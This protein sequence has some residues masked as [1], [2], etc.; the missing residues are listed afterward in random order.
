[1][2]LGYLYQLTPPIA[3]KTKND[4][5]N[6]NIQR[7]NE[8]TKAIHW[9]NQAA[10]HVV[11]KPCLS[12]FKGDICGVKPHSLGRHLRAKGGWTFD[13]HRLDGAKTRRK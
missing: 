8:S 5:L 2:I 6:L 3:Q 9:S 4:M 11:K 7:I 12:H 1:M 13:N 10:I